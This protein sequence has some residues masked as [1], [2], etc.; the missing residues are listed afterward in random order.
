MGTAAVEASI[1]AMTDAQSHRGPDDQGI[2]TAAGVALGHR[3]LSILDLSTAGRQ[4]MHHGSL[5]LTYNGE[6]YNFKEL[7]EELGGPWQS[8]TDSEVILRLY[9]RDGAACVDR[10][11]GMFAFAIWDTAKRELFVARDRLGI[12][13][14]YYRVSGGNLLFASELKALVSGVSPRTPAARG[15]LD[16]GS[17]LLFLQVHPHSQDHLPEHPETPAG[18]P[19]H[20]HTG[21][22]RPGATR[23]LLVPGTV[24]CHQ[25]S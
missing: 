25:R 24:S 8:N 23:A 13:P 18:A 4:P 22:P 12:K 10:L 14:L 17:G 7:R 3:R 21:A 6:I 19:V 2:W 16:G 5:T 15:R 20:R 11:V 9:E 1:Q